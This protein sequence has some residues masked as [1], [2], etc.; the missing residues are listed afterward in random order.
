MF[1]SEKTGKPLKCV[2]KVW[3]RLRGRLARLTCAFMT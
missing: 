2:H 3:E 1:V